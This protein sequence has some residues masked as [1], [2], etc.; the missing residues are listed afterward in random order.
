MALCGCEH[1]VRRRNKSCEVFPE[2]PCDHLP[3]S[4]MHSMPHS[5]ARGSSAP[6]ADRI[7]LELSPVK[8][9]LAY[10]FGLGVRSHQTETNDRIVSETDGLLWASGRVCVSHSSDYASLGGGLGGLQFFSWERRDFTKGS[11]D[12]LEPPCI[13]MC[14]AD[15]P[16]QVQFLG[17][18][19]VSVETF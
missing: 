4:F 18:H 17:N 14:V 19:A 1:S 11:R 6:G 9:T 15:A 5:H 2:A 13:M 8:D 12:V 10:P 7:P 3:I 16:G